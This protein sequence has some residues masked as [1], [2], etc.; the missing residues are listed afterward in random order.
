MKEMKDFKSE[1]ERSDKG[2][3]SD[4]TDNI[5]ICAICDG[6][7]VLEGKLRASTTDH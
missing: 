3:G 6:D 5:M 4:R 1:R 2:N 7:K